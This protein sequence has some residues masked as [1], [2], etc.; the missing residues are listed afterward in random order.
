METRN[1]LYERTT[2]LLIT[3]AIV[4]T[5]LIFAWII[6]NG[7][8]SNN[9]HHQ[10]TFQ[11]ERIQQLHGTILYL[12]EVLTMSARMASTSNDPSWKDRYLEFEP[13][14]SSA[15][16][17]LMSLANDIDINNLIARTAGA[18]AQLVAME[19]QAFQLIDQRRLSEAKAILFSEEYEAQ[20][21]IYKE[22]IDQLIKLLNMNLD[23]KMNTEKVRLKWSIVVAILSLTL[24]AIAWLF[25]L[26]N[27][28]KSRTILL[29]SLLKQEQL[30]DE[31]QESKNFFSAIIEHAPVAIFAKN[32]NDNLKVVLWNRS[33][34]EIFGIPREEIIGH[35]A[36]DFWPKEQADSYHA[37]DQQVIADGQLV[38]VE[39]ASDTANRK[40]TYL[41]TRKV[42][43][44][45]KDGRPTHLLAIC[46]DITEQKRFKDALQV[47]EERYRSLVRATSQIV[48]TMDKNGENFS[49]EE[50]QIITGQSK[51]ETQ[52]LGWFNAIHP[53]DRSFFEKQWLEAVSNKLTLDV[54]HRLITKESDYRFFRTRSIPIIDNDGEVKE[55]IGATVDITKRKMVETSLRESEER[56]R[57]LFENSPVGIYRTSPTGEILLANPAL[58]HMLGYE[59]FSQLF[60]H[61]LERDKYLVPE[62]E[63][64]KREI[65]LEGEVK[66][67]EAVWAKYDGT[68]II[69]REHARAI[70]SEDGE[71]IFYEGTAEDITVQ[72]MFEDQLHASLSLNQNVLDSLAANIA[73]VDKYGT[74]I[75]VN[76]NWKRFSAK[77]GGI[78]EKTNISVNY[79]EVCKVA[80]AEDE[81]AKETYEGLKSILEGFRR[82]FSI[83]YQC[84]GPDERRWFFLTI[85]PLTRVDGGAVISHVDIT[86]RKLIEEALQRSNAM[87]KAQQEATIDGILAIDENERVIGFNKRFCDL[88]NIPEEIVKVSSNRELLEYVTPQLKDP[89]AFFEQIKTLKTTPYEPKRDEVYLMDGR[90][91]DRYVAHIISPIGAF[92]GLTIY[93]RDIT[94][95]KNIQAELSKARD[96]AMET[97]RLKSEFLA[98]MSHEIR[99]PMNGVKGMAGL[100]LNTELTP[101]Q[102]EYTQIIR[103]S[104]DSLLTIINDI[105][106]FSKIEAGK[107]HF[108]TIDFNLRSSLE[109]LV[110]LFAGQARPK[111][112]ELVSF[113]NNDVPVF[114]RG[115]VSR[116]RQVLTNL[117]GNAV[118]FTPRGEVVIKV[119]YE[120]ETEK[121][122]KIRFEIKD[123]GIGFSEE[124]YPHLF[125]AFSQADGS[126]TRKYGGTGLGLAISKHLVERM[127]GEIGAISSP[128][129]GSTFWFTIE[130]E[131]HL[132]HESTPLQSITGLRDVRVLIIDDNQ[133]SRS[134]LNE[135]VVSWGM[136]SGSAIAGT[137]AINMLQQEATNGTPYDLAIIDLEMPDMDGLEVARRI[138]DHP[139]IYSTKLILMA[140]IDCH[141]TADTIQAY[142]IAAC[143]TKPVKQSQLF[144]A[145]LA[146][147]LNHVDIP[148]SRR[149]SK[150][151]L[152]KRETHYNVRILVAEDSLINQKVIAGILDIIGYQFDVVANGLEA[153]EALK[154]GAYDLVL[155]DC[156][157]PEL[158]GYEATKLIREMEGDRTHTPIVA[159]TAHALAGERER[160]LM[161]GMDDYLSKPFEEKDLCRIL[162][163]WTKSEALPR[164]RSEDLPFNSIEI[165]QLIDKSQ[166]D[167]IRE[168]ESKGN[169]NLL[170]EM[171]EL[172]IEQSV[173]NLLIL[174]KGIDNRVADEIERSAHKMKSESGSLGII[175]VNRICSQLEA[176]GRSKS[177]ENVGDLF[178]ELK[179]ECERAYRALKECL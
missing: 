82:G 144:D 52:E 11:T 71:T 140:P 135:Q 100:L 90:V 26:N 48:W 68:K 105:L 83:E 171:V 149:V 35:N 34:E 75:A 74:I 117:I 178:E 47:N 145:L 108:E 57:N 109:E 12:D 161:V 106:D 174:K 179:E 33:A 55:W 86:K 165:D 58:I 157:M 37:I 15:V 130:L 115:D 125:E 146:V 4:L 155:M 112:I 70:K 104:A 158:D 114:V 19:R 43:L 124:A 127:N 69:I 77:N 156:Q 66:G 177:L 107:L 24:S 36:Y 22:S 79:L 110:E 10:L 61:N 139:I 30:E 29:E 102:L 60:S 13:K 123:T 40:R 153:V 65:E 93:F 85:S 14:L 7:Y 97:T 132:E 46:D 1:L 152:T 67:R 172:Y 25:A 128:G 122:I 8:Y 32:V 126:M 147:M 80:A 20:K 3:T 134:S 23:N 138:K 49:S 131:K 101:I 84:H 116:L 9:I 42:P 45:S 99:T 16:K 76:E 170:K 129:K 164:K 50:W 137:E 118:K 162:E 120:S 56:Y 89:E 92:N 176:I 27:L 5:G 143:I 173:E 51:E 73:V 39:E 53:D 98:N 121:S 21:Q 64:F 18:N 148:T 133:T 38:Q 2:I 88:W 54:E 175:R 150:Q 6:L 96:D 41:R 28:Y 154:K 113:I 95:Y 44:F 163:K 167:K 151:L 141:Y 136:C 142:G 72:K 63:A 160:C 59:S 62:R 94:D 17:E 119:S 78:P 168:L 103:E 87:L 81:T 31:L 169:P 166:I 91:F 111:G 159:L